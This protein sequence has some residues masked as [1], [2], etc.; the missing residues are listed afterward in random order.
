MLIFGGEI[1]CM[2]N[3]L[4]EIIEVKETIGKRVENKMLQ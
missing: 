4:R 1:G 2:M 3:Y